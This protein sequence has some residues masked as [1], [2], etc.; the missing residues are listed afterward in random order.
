M[1]ESECAEFV[2]VQ[3]IDRY[4]RCG[5]APGAIVNVM[6]VMPAE[7][8]N[9]PPSDDGFFITTNR[10]LDHERRRLRALVERLI[11]SRLFQWESV[12]GNSR[13]ALPMLLTPRHYR[14]ARQS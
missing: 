3:V 4:L 10:C 1:R 6:P 9:P 5:A 14:P 13:Q 2:F 8:K 12:G 7:T 11:T